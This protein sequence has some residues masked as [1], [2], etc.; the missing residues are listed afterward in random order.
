MLGI[1]QAPDTLWT[2]LYGRSGPDRAYAIE[3]ASDSGYIIAGATFTPNPICNYDIYLIKINEQGDTVWTKV[4]GGQYN[5]GARCLR[6]T[7]DGGYIITGYSQPGTTHEDVYLVKIDDSGNTVWAK[8]YG[9]AEDDC[10]Y[11]VQQTD[12]GGYIIVGHMNIN[13]REDIYLLKTDSS[14]DTLW[15]RRYGGQFEDYGRAVIQTS[16]GGYMILGYTDIA[17]GCQEYAIWLIRTDSIGDTLWTRTYSPYYYDERGFAMQRT[18]DG[19]YV[20]AGCALVSSH[21]WDLLVMKVDSAGDTL[22]KR[23]SG[24][25]DYEYGYSVAE[26]HE[27]G[28]IVTGI[29]K[30]SPG[31]YDIYIERFDA[32]GNTAWS[33]VL[34][35][36]EDD[37]SYAIIQTPDRGYL[38][39]GYTESFGAS[40]ADVYIIRLAPDSYGITEL[41]KEDLFACVD[42]SPNPFRNSTDIRYQITDDGCRTTDSRVLIRIFDASGRLVKDLSQ[43]SVISH[44]S[45]VKWDGTDSNNARLSNGLYFLWLEVGEYTKMKKLL[46]IR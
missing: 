40:N 42:V 17:F 31:D 14:G 29:R 33:K 6:C 41:Y 5:D 37:E 2:K 44:Q 25:Q 23:I 26:T 12:D 30:P 36:T 39:A 1:A 7:S 38:I 28:Y 18:T 32:F 8:T 20:I 24:G 35:G 43:L 3:P 9:G 10:G 4:L 16:D 19:G 46:M 27:G 21:L 13:Y 45:S 22:W 34:G 15:T 11:C